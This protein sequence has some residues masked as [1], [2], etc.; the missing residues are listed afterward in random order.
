MKYTN[1]I[2]INRPVKEVVEKFD[3]AE[4][5]FKWMTGLQEYE[6]ISGE[7][8]RPGAKSR[9]FVKTGKREMDMTET[10]LSNN[11]PDEFSGV[12]EVPG[13]ENIQINRF[14]ELPDNKTKYVCESE[15]KF[16]KFGL[17]LIGFLFPGAFKKQSMGYMQNF[18]AFVEGQ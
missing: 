18:K 5:L 7:P 11:L 6:H 15:F 3:S 8:G 14:I 10:I 12:Y 16:E 9:L 1:E 17:K 2:I 13:I 4:N